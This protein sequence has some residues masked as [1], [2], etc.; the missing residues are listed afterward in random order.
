MRSV[1]RQ[2]KFQSK[3]LH[4]RDIM[5]TTVSVQYTMIWKN[6]ILTEMRVRF[7]C[8]YRT[9]LWNIAAFSA[10]EIINVT[11]LLK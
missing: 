3:F 4:H 9:M 2:I 8:D 7:H 10:I 1:W 5:Y 11:G 6:S